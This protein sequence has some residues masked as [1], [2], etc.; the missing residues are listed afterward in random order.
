M[1]KEVESSN[2]SLARKFIWTA[3][4]TLLT[5]FIVGVAGL[6]WTMATIPS[7]IAQNAK[8]GLETRELVRENTESI[9][10]ISKQGKTLVE[11]ATSLH[12]VLKSADERNKLLDKWIS[13]AE[14]TAEIQASRTTSIKAIDRHLA[15]KEIHK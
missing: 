1:V 6:I 14:K 2:K 7:E 13:K 11:I 3:G 4:T 12:F 10:E 8:Y 15:D 5:A 9:K